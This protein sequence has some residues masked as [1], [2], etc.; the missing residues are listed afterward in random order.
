MAIRPVLLLACALALASGARPHGVSQ[1]TQAAVHRFLYVAEPGIRNYVEYG[2]IGVLVFDMDNGHRFVRRIPTMSPT[3]GEEPENVKGIAAS[4][5]TGRLYVSTIKRVLAFDLA[6]DELLWNRT[7]D[8]GCDRLA[9]SPDGAM[10]YVPSFEGPHW[11][12]STPHRRPDRDASR[13][14]PAPTTPFYGP[15]AGSVYLAGLKSP[16][17]VVV[18]ATHARPSCAR[19]ARSAT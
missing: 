8:G 15:T 18:D 7:Y 17:S 1:S 5:A 4:A 3:A 6:T 14:A 9:I 2:G 16:S 13:R 19:S 11:T 12:W 10:L